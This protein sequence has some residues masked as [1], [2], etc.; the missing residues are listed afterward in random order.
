M[1]IPRKPPHFI[2]D[3]SLW[4]EH[5]KSEKNELVEQVLA[6]ISTVRR[7]LWDTNLELTNAPSEFLDSLNRFTKGFNHRVIIRSYGP[8]IKGGTLLCLTR[9]AIVYLMRL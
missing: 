9:R 3:L 4:D 2:I 7:Y 8:D 1:D 6:S 5:T